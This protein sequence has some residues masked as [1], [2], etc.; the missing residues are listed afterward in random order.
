MLQFIVGFII[1]GVVVLTLYGMI[2]VSG[3]DEGD[4]HYKRTR[5]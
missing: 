5:K 3:D 1:G 4:G 2:L